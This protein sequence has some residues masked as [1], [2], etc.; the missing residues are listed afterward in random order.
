MAKALRIGSM[1]DV[2]KSLPDTVA[3]LERYK[4]AGLDPRVRVPDLRARR[5]HPAGRGG[6]PGARDRPGHRRGARVPAPPDDAGRSRPSRCS[7]PRATG[8]C[9]GIGLS[10]QVVVEGIWGMSFDRPARYM[11]EYLGLADATAAGRGGQQ[12]RGARHH[13]RLPAHR[14]P[15]RRGTA[16]PRR[17]PGP[18]HAQAGGHRRRRHR[19]L[20]DRHRDHRE[21]HRADDH[22]GRARRP[23]GR[24]RGSSC[25][26]RSR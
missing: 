12:H 16:G 20:D 22:R 4:E 25:P 18:R 5:P 8:F 3:Q 24:R 17:R 1:I 21:P 9:S 26:C 10:H 14:D 6:R 15:R 7:G 13:Q 19:D 11:K 23:A 2:D